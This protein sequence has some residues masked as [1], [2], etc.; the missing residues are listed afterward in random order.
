M[1]RP[2]LTARLLRDGGPSWHELEKR[3]GSDVVR[4]ALR[5]AKRAS[6]SR[7]PEENATARA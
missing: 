5:R 7:K 3:D 6:R 4:R 2:R 1:G